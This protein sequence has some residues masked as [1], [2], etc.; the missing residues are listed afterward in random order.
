[1]VVA[2]AALPAPAGAQDAGSAPVAKC[3]G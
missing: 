3:T 2:A 1:L